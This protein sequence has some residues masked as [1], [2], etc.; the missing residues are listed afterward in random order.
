M[1]FYSGVIIFC[2]LTLLVLAIL[3]MEN[4]RLEKR[5]K[6]SFYIAYI[7]VAL[8]SLAEWMGFHLYGNPD[9]PAPLIVLVK[10]MDYIL[11]PMA[12]GVLVAHMGAKDIWKK[13]LNIILVVNVAFQV[14]AAFTGWMVRLDSGNNFSHGPLYTV[15]IAISGI[16]MVIVMIIFIRYGM[17]F[18]RQNRKS[19]YG[20]MIL[21]MLGVIFQ[22]VVSEEIKTVY[23]AMTIGA[24]LMFIHY[25]EFSQQRADENLDKQHVLITT[26][27]LTGIGSRYAYI[28]TLKTYDKNP[29][30][31]DLAVFLIDINGLKEVNDRYGHEAGDELIKGAAECIKEACGDECYRIGG[32]E[33][34]LFS[35]M[36]KSETGD[37]LT[38]LSKTVASWHGEKV[39][40]LSVSAGCAMAADFPG[41]SAEELARKADMDMYR[42]KARYYEKKGVD[43]RKNYS[44]E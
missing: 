26:D 29:L 8:A 42:A 3:V 15:Y 10:T 24:S 32:D 30:P 41:L 2:W 14:I 43:R 36:E 28:D 9:I 27:A 5:I 16:V 19:L 6:R 38:R 22:E 31:E 34:V 4:D 17:K 20:I 23:L 33:F 11:T 25:T 40:S 13:M 7:I 21:I 44:F 37:F 35:S 39:Q 18:K 12:G 1:S